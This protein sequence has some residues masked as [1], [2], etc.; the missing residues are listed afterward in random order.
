MSDENPTPSP[1]AAP[2]VGGPATPS[3]PPAAPAP[4]TGGAPMAGVTPPPMVP[5]TDSPVGDYVTASAPARKG[6]GRKVV[7]G[8]AAVAL[9]GAG[10]FAVVNLAGGSGGGAGSPDEAVQALLDAA[11]A[12]DLI[13]VMDAMAPS[14]RNL[15]KDPMVD[16]MTELKRLEVLSEDAKLDGIDGIDFTF[17]DVEMDVDELADGIALVEL[18]GGTANVS[19]RIEELPLGDLLIEQAFDGER[20]DGPIDEDPEDMDGGK[21][22]AIEEDGSWYVSLWYT[23]AEAARDDADLPMPDFGSGFTANGA[24]T[25]EDAVRDMLDALV[26]LDAEAIVSRLPPTEYR[27]LYDYIPLVVDDADDAA[28]SAL[29]E[30]SISIDELETEVKGSGDRRTVAI[31]SFSASI[32][33]E[34]SEMSMTYADGCTTIDVDGESQETCAEDTGEQLESLGLGSLADIGF[35][36]DAGLVVRQ[37]G[38]KWFVDPFSTITDSMLSFMR[39]IERADIDTFIE[40]LSGLGDSFLGTSDD[41]EFTD[42]FTDDTTF[43]FTDDTTFDTLPDDGGL[44]TLETLPDDTEGDI[45]E[46]FGDDP[47][48]ACYETDDYAQCLLDA[49]ANGELD[50]NMLPIDIRY[51]ECFGDYYGE[52]YQLSDDEFIARVNDIRTCLQPALDAGEIDEFALPAEIAAPQCVTLNPYNFE[53]AP[54]DAFE[55]LYDCYLEQ[56]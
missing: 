12:E 42:E 34:G 15:I 2:N 6:K 26:S 47:F 32:S 22:V 14:E 31:T 53:T 29:E 35:G 55:K 28:Q 52:S 27:V 11:A 23:V 43:D 7:A 21:L 48:S 45:E 50:E 30:V 33:A 8:V 9:L 5:P 3:T 37:E 54:E 56:P 51:P 18:T 19:G 49:V 17:D 10:G 38:G 1:W 24:D 40:E 13:G 44:T 25:P 46:D 16:M 36:E 41:F 4:P 39:S 20:P